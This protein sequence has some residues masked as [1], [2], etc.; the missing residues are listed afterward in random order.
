MNSL[1]KTNLKKRMR[2]KVNLRAQN[3]SWIRVSSAGTSLEASSLLA[4]FH[5]ARG[6]TYTTKR[7]EFSTITSVNP[8]SYNNN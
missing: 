7:E 2:N 6:S 4:C 5:T 1:I 8:A 3:C